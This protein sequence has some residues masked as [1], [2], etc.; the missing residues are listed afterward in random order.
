VIDPNVAGAF[1]RIAARQRD[2][3]HAFEP[4][5]EPENADVAARS[6][7]QPSADPLSAAA[8]DGTYFAAAA[9]G[10]GEVS[11]SRAGAFALVDGELR[12]AGDGR[13]VLGFA[14]DRGSA[15]VPLRVDPYD[16]ALGRVSNA[17]VEADGTFAYTRTTIDPRGGER[18][19]ERVNV[20]RVAL[21]RFP[22]G[23]QPERLDATHVRAPR[24]IAPQIGR[25]GDGPFGA[26]AVHARDLGRVD[27]IAGLE[28]MREAYD[29]LDAIRAS[30]RAHGSIER[31]TMDL[32]K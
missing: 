16:A 5:F 20:G 17:H 12:F 25:P 29:D 4:G 9:G 6:G 3:M 2:V 23:T 10:A 26:L 18:R 14:F 15:L 28:R 11:F 30:S 32:L 31:T 13:A 27:V 8:P 21:A 1:A 7:V 22:A 24:G 19:T